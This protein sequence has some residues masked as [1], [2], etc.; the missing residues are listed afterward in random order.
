M[1]GQGQSKFSGRT[2]RCHR[3]QVLEEILLAE[4]DEK[5]K[6]IAHGIGVEARLDQEEGGGNQDD[7]FPGFQLS[8]EPSHHAGGQ[9]YNAEGCADDGGDEKDMPFKLFSFRISTTASG[10]RPVSSSPS[11][12]P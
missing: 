9:G 2:G 3:R 4:V 1:D 12:G 8:D 7:A 10:Y 5:E 11:A 6:H